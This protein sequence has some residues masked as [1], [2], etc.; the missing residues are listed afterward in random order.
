MS[1]ASK[2]GCASFMLNAWEG[3]PAYQLRGMAT[4]ADRCGHGIGAALLAHA[5][6]DLQ[7]QTDVRLLWGNARKAAIGFYEKQGWAIASE[8]FEIPTVGPHLKI[9]KAI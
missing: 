1:A 8:E 3:E 7:R 9:V 2:I 6:A 4:R 5:I